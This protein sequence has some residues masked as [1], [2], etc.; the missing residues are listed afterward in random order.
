MA[1]IITFKDLLVWQ[2]AHELTILIYTTTKDFP[3]EER[4][5]LVS[6]M[7]RAAVS[8]ASNIV[9][10]FRRK[11]LKDSINFYNIADASLEE[12]KYQILLC[13][14]LHLVGE[15]NFKK[16]MNLAEETSKM[17][18]GWIKKCKEKLSNIS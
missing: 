2:K 14:D 16:L 7:R 13:F 6:Q 8:V 10:G 18:Y 11:S 4:Y 15:Y 1:Q 3:T 12:L 9:E 5:G 17:L